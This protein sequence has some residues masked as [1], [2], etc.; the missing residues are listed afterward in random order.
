MREVAKQRYAHIFKMHIGINMIIYPGLH[1]TH[2]LL[3]IK[4]RHQYSRCKKQH[5]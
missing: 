1:Q 5:Y 3:L 4:Y 2:D